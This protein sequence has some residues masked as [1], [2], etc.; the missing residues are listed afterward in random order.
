M[1]GQNS[2]NKHD[3]NNA[4]NVLG[5]MYNTNQ[6]NSNYT[7]KKGMKFFWIMIIVI[8]VASAVF[9]IIRPYPTIN[10]VRADDA[11][12][13]TYELKINVFGRYDFQNEKLFPYTDVDVSYM[14]LTGEYAQIAIS[15]VSSDAYMIV[16]DSETLQELASELSFRG[17]VSYINVLRVDADVLLSN[18]MN[19][20]FGIPVSADFKPSPFEE[21]EYIALVPV[22]NILT[23]RQLDKVLRK[24]TSVYD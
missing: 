1:S 12:I 14:G 7:E 15:A 21:G 4:G 3:L 9:L 19:G 6:Y 23:E 16:S 18:S 2:G 13:T 17:A 11:G 8:T 22:S 10:I 24:L 5:S 20:Y